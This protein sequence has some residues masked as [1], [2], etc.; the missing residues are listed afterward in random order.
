MS[1]LELTKWNK[2]FENHSFW[3]AQ[4]RISIASAR[5]ISV[6]KNVHE[7]E[8]LGGSQ[9]KEARHENLSMYLTATERG[10]TDEHRFLDAKPHALNEQ[11]IDG[12]QSLPFE[13]TE[14]FASI[15]ASGAQASPTC[16]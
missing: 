3:N 11:A 16:R 9:N 1:S 2:R 10:L 14:G 15:G 8:S 7:P 4:M 5:G 13:T 6:C 12:L